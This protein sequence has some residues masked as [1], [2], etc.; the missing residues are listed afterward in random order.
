MAEASR[1]TALS[2]AL[3]VGLISALA[4]VCLAAP[5]LGY[6]DA[7]ELG[8]ASFVLGVP[9][10][11][12]FPLDMLLLR[13]GALLPLGTVAWRQN[14]VVALIAG[15]AL[16]LLFE[17]AARIADRV[18][19][20]PGR[21]GY[22]GALLAVAALGCW[23]AFFGSALAVEVYCTSLLL[24]ALAGYGAL[25]GGRHALLVFLAAGLAAG[26]HVTALLVILP[27]A[28]ALLLS[29]PAGKRLALLRAGLLL[30]ALC[31]LVVSYLPLASLRDPV[32]D[33]GDPES[34]GAL[35]A[36][37]SAA[38]IRSAFGGE[39]L[40]G[41][42]EA[43]LRFGDQL[44]ELWPLLVPAV[45]GCV[46]AMA[47]ARG[48]TLLLL[49]LL[50]G[51][52]CYA[53]WIH[54]MGIE[55]RQVGHLLAAVLAL[56]S[57][58]GAA[59]LIRSAWRRPALRL[60]A[61]LTVFV[62]CI[63]MAARVPGDTFFDRYTPA[64]LHAGGGPLAALPPRAVLL[65]W[66][67]G[68]CGGSL[69]ALHVERVRPDLGVAPAQ[70]L[71]DPTVVRRLGRLP[72][73]GQ[74]ASSRTAPPLEKRRD[75]ARAR[76]RALAGQ[77]APRPLF[78]ETDEPL[79]DAGFR[80]AM[81]ISGVA[82]FLRVAEKGKE[83]GMRQNRERDPIQEID[84]LRGARLLR[85]EPAAELARAAWARAYDR[86]GRGALSSRRHGWAVAAMSRAVE[87][88]PLRAVAWINLGVALQAAGD[89]PAAEA[90]QR[91]AIEIEPT[92][93][94]AWVNLA[95]FTLA[96]GDRKTARSILDLA[97]ESG[98]RDPRLERLR[99]RLGER[100]GR[101]REEQ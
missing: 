37:L 73:L 74:N 94:T 47:R 58:L 35:L 96:R 75:A 65:C 39:M 72:A 32:M 100:G 1:D 50:V 16:G 70:H 95:R 87:L 3:A 57:G 55:Q 30:A 11:T 54:P 22:A 33:W 26:A 29:L 9:H 61:G 83:P 2:P 76:V 7:G 42:Q 48:M 91:R 80:G 86:A 5:D 19:I 89:L 85:G 44:V 90:T 97:R 18:G 17:L 49:L 14:M 81:E 88:T 92:R 79:R 21:G 52:F 45:L 98:I 12:G 56:F 69:F 68:V 40:G 99:R 6:G 38:R 53:V 41:D 59:A 4:L 25:R 27:V 31:A 63:A 13:L 60:A 64:E 51:D 23:P 82:P 28:V 10:P 62:L 77:P 93:P 43:L 78:W 8:T 20:A 101:K 67:D 84:R 36:H 24:G 71:W 34:P 46:F 15:A 66:S